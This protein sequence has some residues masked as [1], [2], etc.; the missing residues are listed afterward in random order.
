MADGM[1]LCRLR[2]VGR[3]VGKAGIVGRAVGKPAGRDGRGGKPNPNACAAVRQMSVVAVRRFIS[4]LQIV[5]I[6]KACVAK[7]S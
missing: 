2:P 4:S 6:F 7:L 1:R 5:N 3:A